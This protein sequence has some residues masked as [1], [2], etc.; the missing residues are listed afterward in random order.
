MKGSHA[1]RPDRAAATGY[2]ISRMSE[3]TQATLDRTMRPSEVIFNLG[4]ALS[5]VV[6]AAGIFVAVS[7][8]PG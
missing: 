8:E 3:L 1:E 6:A 2:Y 5:V 4:I 7:V